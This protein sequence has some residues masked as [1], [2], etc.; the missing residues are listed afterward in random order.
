MADAEIGNWKVAT[1]GETA[2]DHTKI[3]IEIIISC[4]TTDDPL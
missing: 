3:S 2:S 1:C 4:A